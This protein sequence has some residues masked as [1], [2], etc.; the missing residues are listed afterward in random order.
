MRNNN[1]ISIALFCLIV[2][3]AILPT[4]K[5]YALD[6]KT[7]TKPQPVIEFNLQDHKNKPYNNN[8]LKD[9][10]SMIL[11]GYTHCPDVCPFTLSNLVAVMEQ[12]SLKV[13]PGSQ[14][15]MVFIGVDPERDKP[16]LADYLEHFHK[17][18][19]GATGEWAQIKKLVEG[20]DGFVRLN[21][22]N[23]ED[24]S[25]AVRH[26]SYVYIVNPEG[27]LHARMNPPFQPN[28]TADF[29]VTLMR[30]YKVAK[31]LEKPQS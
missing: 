3:I 28:V 30:K 5:S 24:D 12:I 10:W 1:P 22:K 27:K 4:E 26:S 15:K 8:N 2:A 29:I 6:S 17:D 7:F 19:I 11:L 21:K 16:V 9:G 31:N 13:S 14:P 23:A 25:Y 18:F 20:L